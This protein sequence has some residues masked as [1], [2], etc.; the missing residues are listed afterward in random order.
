MTSYA[1][2]D[3]RASLDQGGSVSGSSTV[4]GTAATN[5]NI[6]FGLFKFVK[7]TNGLIT[8]DSFVFAGASH[9]DNAN[10][11]ESWLGDDQVSPMNVGGNGPVTRNE[12]LFVG[13]QFR[14]ESSSRNGCLTGDVQQLRGSARFLG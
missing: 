6:F 9:L 2:Q 7:A 5:A 1:S 3:N 11:A 8:F 10:V 4:S 14:I 12:V 13:E